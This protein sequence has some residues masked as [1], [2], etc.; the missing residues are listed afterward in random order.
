MIL[1]FS[2]V[3]LI[4]HSDESCDVSNLVFIACD[5]RNYNQF[6][7]SAISEWETESRCNTYDVVN[8]M[9]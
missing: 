2:V 5:N 1:L 3:E 6:A 8:E 9:L 4:N 7:I